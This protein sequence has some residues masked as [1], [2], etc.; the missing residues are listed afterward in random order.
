MKGYVSHA[1]IGLLSSR[2]AGWATYNIFSTVYLPK[3]LRDY[4]TNS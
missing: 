4:P 1:W 2:L 3:G